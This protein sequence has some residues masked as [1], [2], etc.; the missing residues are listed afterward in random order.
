MIIVCL[1]GLVGKRWRYVLRWFSFCPFLLGSTLGAVGVGLLP[2]GSRFR[3]GS[4]E[5]A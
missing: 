2:N 4:G 1:T 3:L 5:E